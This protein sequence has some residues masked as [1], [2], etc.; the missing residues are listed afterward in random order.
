MTTTATEQ[1]TAAS[2]RWTVDREKT[3]V[4]FTVKTFWGLMTVRGRFS[5]FEGSY[6][7]GPHGPRIELTVGACSLDTANRK[8]DEHLRSAD[9]F[10][11]EQ[12][13]EVRFTSTRVCPAGDGMEV[14]GVLEAAGRVVPLELFTTVH[15]VGEAR[16]VE[17]TTTVD[18]ALL[19][20]SSGP[21]GM[22]RRPA[23]LR[24]KA[25]LNRVSSEQESAFSRSVPEI[26]RAA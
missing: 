26:R 22:I 11:V 15:Q 3:S 8:R 1:T 20:M 18:H 21:L 9:F 4:D 24:V 17:A 23:T 10:D 14:E 19:G 12:H 5:R 13:P 25:R 2:T 6:E 16:Q 7:M